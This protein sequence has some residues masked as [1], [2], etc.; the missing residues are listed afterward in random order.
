M[1]A[2]RVRVGVG[3]GGACCVGGEDGSW[4][5]RLELIRRWKMI[6]IA[7]VWESVIDVGR[8]HVV[9][10]SETLRNH[11]PTG[12]CIAPCMSVTS[13]REP[14]ALAANL[15]HRVFPSL[16]R[17]QNCTLHNQ[18]AVWDYINIQSPSAHIHISINFKFSS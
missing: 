15:I 12:P 18:L 2:R 7:F 16:T 6:A 8:T 10:T 4:L 11:L 3:E 5:G 9:F 17:S 13:D 14:R 1:G